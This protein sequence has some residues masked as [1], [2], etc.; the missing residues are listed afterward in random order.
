MVSADY[1][2]SSDGNVKDLEESAGNVY[3]RSPSAVVSGSMF[4]QVVANLSVKEAASPS[5]T[6]AASSKLGSHADPPENS[7]GEIY[8]YSQESI[9]DECRKKM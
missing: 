1:K 7:M 5:A 3:S 8:T 4:N 2:Q 9:V 6:G